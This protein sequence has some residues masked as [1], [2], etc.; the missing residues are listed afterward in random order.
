MISIQIKH[1][2]PVRIFKANFISSFGPFSHCSTEFFFFNLLQY[3]I[4]H[5]SPIFPYLLAVVLQTVAFLEH[6]VFISSSSQQS[7]CLLQNGQLATL[8]LADNS[9]MALPGA[10]QA[11]EHMHGAP[12]GWALPSSSA[13]LPLQHLH[14]PAGPGVRSG[15]LCASFCVCCSSSQA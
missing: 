9:L 8:A 1:L 7:K 15:V 11:H 2:I 6:L 5:S 12:S 10:V 4:S 14:V 13:C 3:C